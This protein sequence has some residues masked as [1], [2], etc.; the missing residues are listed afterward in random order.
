M[1]R[2]KILIIAAKILRTPWLS[3]ILFGCLAI[4]IL[5]PSYSTFFV[6]PL[7]VD[8]LA[9]D[10]K[11]HASRVAIHLLSGLSL[12]DGQLT[13]GS[14][15]KKAIRDIRRSIEDFKLEKINA[16]SRS[17]EV[18]YSTDEHDIGKINKNAY[19]TEIVAKGKQYLQIVEK[20]MKTAENRLADRD[21]A[22]VYIPVMHKNV[23][24]GAF[25]IYY[26][27]TERKHKLDKLL[28]HSSIVLYTTTTI[29]LLSVA[30]M[31]FKITESIV[32]REEAEKKLAESH[33]HLERLVAEQIH[34]ITVTQ[35]TSVEAL[36][37]L[38]EY[39]DPDTGKHLVRIR[40]YVELL[41]T[42][43]KGHSPY[44]G[45]ISGKADYVNEVKFASILHDIGKVAI[46]REILT[47]PG[48]LTAEEFDLVKKHTLVAGEVLGKANAVFVDSFGKDSYLALARDIA[49]YHHEKW[50]GSGYPYGLKGESIPLSARIVALADVYDALVSTRPY[51]SP[52]SHNEAINIIMKEK[53]EHFDPYVVEA[54]LAQS[55]RFYEISHHLA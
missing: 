9:D 12:S 51:K 25:E 37:I 23:F 54:F 2:K 20:N 40:Q 45:Y 10:T 11:D 38:A 27:I 22:E 19:F 7:F 34:E 46:K 53:G 47:R 39:Y 31:L 4:A 35:R 26:D 28:R 13:K 6:M 5:L 21:L 17:G 14:F 44:S 15:S 3:S 41:A 36:V 42:W 50:N 55:D 16:F 43:L 48:K 33:S 24:G 29:F 8:Q 30:I 49:L 18:L 32:R 1:Q 52:L